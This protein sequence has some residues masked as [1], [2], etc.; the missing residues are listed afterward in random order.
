MMGQI[1]KCPSLKNQ[2][3]RFFN[4][5]KSKLKMSDLCETNCVIKK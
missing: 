2:R 1:G 4:K 3:K 5:E